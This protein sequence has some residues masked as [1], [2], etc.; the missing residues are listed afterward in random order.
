M[1]PLILVQAFRCAILNS[2]AGT[3]NLQNLALCAEFTFPNVDSLILQELEGKSLT[4]VVSNLN[5]NNSTFQSVVF[6]EAGSRKSTR[7]IYLDSV[8]RYLR[9]QQTSLR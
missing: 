6:S 1:P 2:L 8:R 5:H 7:L 4:L 3:F 9:R